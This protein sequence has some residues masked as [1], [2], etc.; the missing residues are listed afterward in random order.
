[1]IEE[2]PA[3]TA[4]PEPP[5]AAA[6]AAAAAPAISKRESICLLERELAQLQAAEDKL[7]VV[8]FINVGVVCV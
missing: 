8:S 7:L 5:A 3:P 6:A 2:K 1:M 4:A